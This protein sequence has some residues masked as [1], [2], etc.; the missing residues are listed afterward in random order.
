MRRFVSD[1]FEPGRRGTKRIAQ[2]SSSMLWVS[3]STQPWERATS[4][5]SPTLA[6]CAGRVL[7]EGTDD[8]GSDAA[9]RPSQ[10]SSSAAVAFGRAPVISTSVPRGLR[11][12]FAP[13][14]R[15][16]P[17]EGAAGGRP[18]P[19]ANAWLC[20]EGTRPR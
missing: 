3:V 17:D 15:R 11:L 16:G 13:L 5:G 14:S 18:P 7:A 12:P 1:Q 2:R 20:G 8:R 9:Y 6:V 10:P 4:R 19:G